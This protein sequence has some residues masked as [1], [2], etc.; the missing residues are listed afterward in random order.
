M[1]KNKGDKRAHIAH[2]YIQ[3]HNITAS[4]GI[5]IHSCQSKTKFANGFYK[6]IKYNKSHIFLKHENISTPYP[7]T[8]DILKPANVKSF[9]ITDVVTGYAAIIR[10]LYK[11]TFN[12][13]FLCDLLI[14]LDAFNCFIIDDES[15]IVF[16][17]ID[18]KAAI[19]PMKAK[20]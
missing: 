13:V 2:L 20:E 1:S 18:K 4:D 11:A 10:A 14:T 8:K 9:I 17:G 6:V 15:P 16:T 19:M 7:E 3:N 5:R 12:Y